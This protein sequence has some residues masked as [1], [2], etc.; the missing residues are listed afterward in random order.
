M[1]GPYCV[2]PADVEKWWPFVGER[3]AEALRRGGVGTP[4][5]AVRRD[6][7]TG[8]ALL[9]LAI[10]GTG[11]VGVAVTALIAGHSG[12]RCELVAFAGDLARCR[13]MLPVIERYAKEEGCAMMRLMGRL[14]WRRVL[15]GYSEPFVTLE[16][17]L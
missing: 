8:T 17:R 11:I 4:V 1:S 7:E 2:A 14:G 5:D 6:L 16:K 10:E 13:A 12:K 15:E 3:I 9:W